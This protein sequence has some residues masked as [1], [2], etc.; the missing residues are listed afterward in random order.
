MMCFLVPMAILQSRFHYSYV[1]ELGKGQIIVQG[2]ITKLL[3]IAVAFR[4]P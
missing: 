3:E 1:P 2:N 4:M